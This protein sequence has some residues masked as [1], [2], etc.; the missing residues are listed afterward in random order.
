ME[1]LS[2]PFVI[3]LFIGLVLI[4]VMLSNGITRLG[5][6]IYLLGIILI[7]L[8]Y[9][10]KAVVVL[11]GYYDSFPH[12]IKLFLPFHFLIG[13]LF[14]LYVKN[15]LTSNVKSDTWRS[16]SLHFI[17]F[18]I[19]LAL[20]LP[21]Y[22]KSGAEKRSLYSAPQPGNFSVA[23]VMLFYYV[24][25]LFS[26]VFYSLKSVVTIRRS[27][28]RT[29]QRKN[30]S[31]PGKLTWLLN[32]AYAF[33][34]FVGLYLVAQAVIVLTDFKQ[35][36]VMLFTVF[37]SSVFVHF[38]SFWA[39]KGSSVITS[40]VPKNFLAN[41]T[42]NALFLQKKKEITQLLEEEHIF[43]ERDLTAVKF[44]ERLEINT[45]YLS[46]IVNQEF[47]CNLTHLINSHRIAHAKKTLRNEAFDH[48]NFLGIAHHSGFNSA[49][50]FT[51][52]FKKHTGKT[53]SEF[54][55]EMEVV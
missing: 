23:S 34:I 45:S 22:V 28:L 10:F 37:S 2:V 30:A 24:P 16:R 49:N 32:Y 4:A 54:K 29:D 26:L 12:L 9:Q 21:F 5:P 43:L 55:K 15:S 31:Y 48:L 11:E 7:V 52:V 42:S 33:L 38:L 39:M 8:G 41:R 40:E 13:P 14:F 6:N 35:F 53:P 44:A 19:V 50:S 47:G 17:P 3:N 51:R 20:L 36:Y 18:A 25:I 46:Q 27:R 1:V